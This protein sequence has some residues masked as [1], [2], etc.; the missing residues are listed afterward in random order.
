MRFEWDPKKDQENRGKH[1]FSL[2]A[3]RVVFEDP[4]IL[5]EFDDRDFGGEE[6]WVVVGWVGRS[7]P[8]W[9][10]PIV[11]MSGG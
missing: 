11:A 5:D 2:S 7:S 8:T 1:G 10:T 4:N 9:S 3:G 6:R